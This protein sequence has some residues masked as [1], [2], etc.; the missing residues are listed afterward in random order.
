LEEDEVRRLRD[1]H[2]AIGEDEA[3]R[4][5]EL[6]REDRE[7]VG[8]AV[9]VGVFAD[10]D[11]V[12]TLLLVFLDAVRVVRGLADPEATTRVP[13]ERNRLHDVGLGGE[14]HQLHVSRHL[15]A[16]HAA[17]DRVRLLEGQRLGALL[18]V[19]HVDILLADLRL[20]LREELLPGRITG[21][22]QSGF[23]LGAESGGSRVGLHD[24]HLHHRA[25]R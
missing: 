4:D 25:V 12:V 8:L 3:R 20:T 9:A 11:A 18:V 16:L 22:R 23:E 13:R 21:G 6:I 2:A 17:L 15:R 7:L 19:G 24:Q 1:D 14:E 5:V 10:L